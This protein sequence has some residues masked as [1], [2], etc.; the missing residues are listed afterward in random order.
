MKTI[1]KFLKPYKTLT[2][3]TILFIIFDVLGALYIPTIT[4]DMINIG[5]ESKNI[6]YIFQKGL[7]ML[8]VTII[9]GLGALI[10]SYLCSKLASNMGR[11]MR[12]ALYKKS[13]TF[14]HFDFKQF[15]TGSM[16][17]RT[18]NDV[19]V[20]Q[21]TAVA[22]IQMVI[23]VP[24]M[25]VS[26]IVMAFRIDKLMG[27]LLLGITIVIIIAAVFITRKAS[28][29]FEKLQR[30]LD[31]MNVILRENITGVRVIRAFNKEEHE[32]N[33]L[34]D[35]FEK[36]AESAIKA[37]RLY[38]GLDSLAFLAINVCIV[39]ILYIGGNRVGL[40]AM[41]I[42]DITAVTEYAILILFYLIMAQMVLILMP[43]AGICLKRIKE[44]LEAEPEIHDG[45]RKIAKSENND[46]ISFKNMTFRFNDA[47]EDTL[48]NLKF[49]CK[50]GQTTAIIGSTG[51]GK[52]TIAKLIMR[53]HD[54][55]KGSILLNGQDLKTLSKKDIREHISY[56]PQTAWLF[57]GTIADNLRYGNKNATEGEM[58]HALEVA[59]A[60]FV[61]ELEDGLQARVAQGG[62]NFSGG[63]KQRL[64]IARAL[65][66]KADLY[67]FDDSFS[68]LDFKTDANLRKALVKEIK[69]SAILIIAQ[70]I[71]TI[72]N[73][74]QIIVLND[75]KVVGIG[76]HHELMKNCTVY[77]EIAKSQMKGDVDHVKEEG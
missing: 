46:V 8:G 55:T 72:L 29:I 11:D 4:A 67:V 52:S 73:A 6:N 22:F 19:N 70:R 77:Q 59:Q 68:A 18:L 21:Q 20:I 35:S 76:K 71:N 47:D 65:I 75:G 56:V 64:S 66:K 1:F 62:T 5:I 10:G 45:K 36:Y 48:C 12:D 16:I 13:L 58:Y 74:D 60:G 37:N 51:S 33:R 44:V 28:I 30:F 41:Q 25:C 34:K 50:R 39:A 14:S 23:P 53:F 57:S 69:D 27:F 40:G 17:T 38:A 61:E 15:G 54:A 32:K 24:I 9:A 31:K 42:G 3:F 63:Q 49:T 2:V 43:R 7:I 26:G